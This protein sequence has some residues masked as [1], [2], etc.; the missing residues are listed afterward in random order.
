MQRRERRATRHSN[1]SRLARGLAALWASGAIARH[2]AGA[3]L[4]RGWAALCAHRRESCGVEL[5]RVELRRRAIAFHWVGGAVRCLRAWRSAARARR[6]VAAAEDVAYCREGRRLLAS[7]ARGG[8]SS[9][10]GTSPMEVMPRSSD[11]EWL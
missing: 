3:R 11:D 1:R 5:R 8:S 2:C 4:V 6:L 7:P 9:S 10:R